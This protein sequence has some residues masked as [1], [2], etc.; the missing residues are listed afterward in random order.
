MQ[1]TGANLTD[2]PTHEYEVIDKYTKECEG[3]VEMDL[4]KCPAYE[5]I[6]QT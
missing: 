1:T 6:R 3:V 4:I 2:S 5:P